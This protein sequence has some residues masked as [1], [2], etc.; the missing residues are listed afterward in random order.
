MKYLASDSQHRTINN[1]ITVLVRER[2][3][4]LNDIDA[5]SRRI[6]DNREKLVQGVEQLE[7]A[8]RAINDEL[9]DSID[10]DMDRRNRLDKGATELD[11]AITI[12]KNLC[13]AEETLS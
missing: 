8:N 4:I 12:L 3:F 2:R 1:A 6:G 11:R 5:L 9:W 7:P 10:A 13:K